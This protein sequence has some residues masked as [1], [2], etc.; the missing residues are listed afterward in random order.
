MVQA[1]DSSTEQVR[2]LRFRLAVQVF[3]LF[4]LDVDK[5][6]KRPSTRHRQARGIGKIGGFP[7][8]HA[9]PELYGVLPPLELQSALRLVAS[10][11][12]TVARCLGIVLPHPI[13]LQPHSPRGDITET[14]TPVPPKTE[15]PQTQDTAPNH[16]SPL[17][18]ASTAS[19]MSIVE[20]T[21]LAWGR[22]A[23]KALARA[24]GQQELLDD[25]LVIPPSMDSSSV[26]QRLR[27]ATSAVLA[28][29]PSPASSRYALSHGSEDQFAVGLQLL[30]DDVVA[31]CIR[32][33]VPVANLW[34]IEA[35]LL[36]LNALYLY[37]QEQIA[38]FSL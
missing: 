12:S 20:S 32:A 6:E 17:L 31:L 23:K 37:S 34:P 7:L 9:G 21:T 19:L 11:T 29:D 35:L 24:T 3:S 15:N 4:R 16:S 22:T 27:H 14:S 8:P 33:G 13:L 1:I 36:N 28:E 26:S 30:Q 25:T 2:K 18:S 10:L 38:T 5:E